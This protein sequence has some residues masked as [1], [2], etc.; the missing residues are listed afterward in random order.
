MNS[1][2]DTFPKYRLECR[3]GDGRIATSGTHYTSIYDLIRNAINPDSTI[4][5]INK[6]GTK[7][8]VAFVS[9]NLYMECRTADGPNIREI[10]NHVTN[11]TWAFYQ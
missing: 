8:F 4:F 2:E 11:G 3:I 6:D 5:S 1:A 9:S 7:T 10:T